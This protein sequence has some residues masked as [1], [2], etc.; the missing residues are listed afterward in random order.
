VNIAIF[1]NGILYDKIGG[2]QKHMREVL[3]RLSAYH[4]IT[5]FPEPQVYR[6]P[7]ACNK[8]DINTLINGGVH[9]SEFFL[10]NH[11]KHPAIGDIIKNYSHELANCKLIYDLDF[12]Y[13][14]ENFTY[15]GEIS[16]I[17]SEK[18]GIKMGACLQGFGDINM[19]F[20]YETYSGIK[21]SGMIPLLSPFIMAVSYFDYVNR[22]ITLRRLI[23][24]THLSFISIIN[25]DYRENMNLT[26]KN[27][28]IIN[29]PNAIDD[30]IKAHTISTK[31]D[32]IIYF[33]RLIYRKG[34]FDILYILQEILR[35]HDT[36]LVII[37][38]FQRRLEW[39]LFMNMARK[40]HILDKINYMGPLSDDDLYSEL[41][42]SK[43]M[44]YPSHSDSFSIS[45]LQALFLGIPVVSYR[46]AGLAI[47]DQ[48]S[49]VKLVKEFDIKG[50]AEASLEFITGKENYKRDNTL[51]DFIKAH[52][53][54][55][56]VTG[57][58]A[59]IINKYA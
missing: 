58:H 59:R 27:V 14:L 57:E 48:F 35:H 2:A 29:P 20:I 47:Y 51:N 24:N 45:I 36:K 32:K 10:K 23:R 53:N 28:E 43:L 41:K 42:T 11:A 3:G 21:L 34:L 25:S 13:Y 39:D 40:M 9:I 1:A 55:D 33:A 7:E 44:L 4:D 54:W 52:D 26:F 46:I 50:M 19:H 12:Q 30:K 49:S 16:L 38:K 56:I 6:N 17:L 15:G 5:Y 22:N 8:E 18:N 37:G 31:E